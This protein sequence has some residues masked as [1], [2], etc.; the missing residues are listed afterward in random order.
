[1]N[2]LLA[3]TLQFAPTPERARVEIAKKLH[4]ARFW[5]GHEVSGRG[6]TPI[7]A[8]FGKGTSSTRAV[9]TA[10]SSAASSRW[11]NDPLG[12]H[13]FRSLFTRKGVRNN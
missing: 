6:K 1:M 13:F 2:L 8:A 7:R 11:G 12:K 10:E 5:Q 3:E 4:S 9:T